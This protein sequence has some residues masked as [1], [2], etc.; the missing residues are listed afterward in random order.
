MKSSQFLLL[1]LLGLPF[2]ASA[3]HD[4]E[5]IET[6]V[7]TATRTA[8]AADQV[9]APVIVIDR[10]T[11][12]RSMAADLGDLLKFHAGLDIARSGGVGQPTSVFMRGT[13]SNHTLVMI[14]G[15]KI[16]P[17]TAGGAAL[18]QISPALVERIEIVKGPRSSLYGSEAI[19]GVINVITRGHAGPNGV[20]ASLG[21]GSFG[22]DDGQVNGRMSGARGNLGAGVSWLDTDGYPVQT[23]ST[24]ASGHDN[25]S[26]NLSGGLTL[27]GVNVNARHWDARG[28][29]E[30]LDFLL[31]PLD[32]DF[33]NQATTLQLD[34]TPSAS[35]ETSIL[36][37]HV[38]DELTQN[39]SPDFFSTD[40]DALD[41]QNDIQAGI[42]QLTAG[43]YLSAEDTKAMTWG[44]AYAAATDVKAIY[45]QD[46]ISFGS[47]D[48]V[49]AARHTSHETAGN[50]NT[51]NLD[52][53]FAITPRLRLNAGAGTGFRAPDS[54]ER[55]G[56][57]GNPAL[58]PETSTNLELG[59]N[60]RP[61]AL[62]QFWL[63]I[64]RNEIDNLIEYIILD[65]NTYEGIN[66]NVARA[67]IDGLEAGYEYRDENWQFRIEAIAQD[68]TDLDTGEQLLRRASQSLTASAVRNIGRYEVGLD[69]LCS[70]ERK[71]FG[72]PSPVTLPGYGLFN[73]NGRLGLGQNWWLQARIENI[74]D[75]QYQT[76]AGYP[77]ASRGVY[78]SF[79][80]RSF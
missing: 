72:Y 33:K 67:R 24:L 23:G 31:T 5:E 65:F 22:T 11:I 49:A 71:D 9:L 50:H 41:W 46:Q 28:N 3:Q 2:C 25:L 78:L 59:A 60:F 26:V 48:L 63:R 16:N 47:H 40:R 61:D 37:S 17:G 54:S 42:H 58:Q 27:A 6:V 74:L 51:W 62:R 10:A 44:S 76:V 39:Q 45:A 52:Y 19:G 1:T 12:E 75:K 15:V 43:L 14:D 38:V 70:S 4:N 18:Q 53:A 80:Y 69:M 32:Q 36:L 30:Y 55:F 13:E 8:Q 77:S 29:T 68:P 34:A 79:N 73:L 56:F 66:Q 35:W 21:G 20:S 7:V 57:G 64:F